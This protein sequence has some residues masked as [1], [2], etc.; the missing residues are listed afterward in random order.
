[1]KLNSIDY[2]AIGLLPVIWFLTNIFGVHQKFG[3]YLLTTLASIG[4]IKHSVIAVSCFRKKNYSG[5]KVLLLFILINILILILF[6]WLITF[7]KS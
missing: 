7:F 4:V 1:M 3:F 6:L 5:M 2:F